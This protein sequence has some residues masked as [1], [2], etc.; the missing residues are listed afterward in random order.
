MNKPVA[1]LN[2]AGSKAATIHWTSLLYGQPTRIYRKTLIWIVVVT[3]RFVGRRQSL[4]SIR[5]I[6]TR[7]RL[8]LLRPVAFHNH[9]LQSTFWIV[10]SAPTSTPTDAVGIAA[11]TGTWNIE[12]P[13]NALYQPEVFTSSKRHD[14]LHSACI[15]FDLN[16]SKML[17]IVGSDMRA[18]ADATGEAGR[19]H[20]SQRVVADVPET[21]P[22]LGVQRAVDERVRADKSRD[23]RIVHPPVHVD[24]VGGVE[25][26]VAGVA[27]AGEAVNGG[28][29]P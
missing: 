7:I 25:H 11:S 13:K 29:L 8:L 22:A 19:V 15:D 16:F 14:R 1:T 9:F 18:C 12:Y 28:K 26:L 5:S 10:T 27:A 20:G 3:K 24:E 17:R 21:I 6:A 4:R 2:D 23:E